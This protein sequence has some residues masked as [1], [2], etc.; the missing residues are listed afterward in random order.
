MS[1]PAPYWY[2]ISVLLSTQPLTQELA[3]TLYRVA[4]ELH[5]NVEGSGQVDLPV[6]KGVVKNLRQHA[7]LGTVGGP[8]FEAEIET[9][10]GKG[11]VRYLLTKEAMATQ[12]AA[13]GLPN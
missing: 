9:E 7:L 2:L 13:T 10:R 12:P 3:M 1:E 6:A 8:V 11:T 4:A 5:A